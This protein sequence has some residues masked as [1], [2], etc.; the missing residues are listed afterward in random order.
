M[1]H[2][3]R[4]GAEKRGGDWQRVTLSEPLQS[5]E[6]GLDM[7]ELLILDQAIE[8]LAGLDDRQAKIVE[9]RFFACLKVNEVAEILG[10]SKRTVEDDWVH[11]RAWLKRE[12]SQGRTS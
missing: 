12:L 2:A 3:R 8:K 6:R 7:D 11:A 10:V 4:K 1:D 9:L 5:K